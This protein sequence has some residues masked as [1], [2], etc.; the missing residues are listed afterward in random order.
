MSLYSSLSADSSVFSIQDLLGNYRSATAHHVY[1]LFTCTQCCG[2][3]ASAHHVHCLFTCTQY[4]GG[5][6]SAWPVD[7]VTQCAEKILHLDPKNSLEHYRHVFIRALVLAQVTESAF[8]EYVASRRAQYSA[9]WAFILPTAN[10]WTPA[11]DVICPV[12]KMPK[13]VGKPQKRSIASFFKPLSQADRQTSGPSAA[14]NPHRKSVCGWWTFRD[15][16]LASTHREWSIFFPIRLRNCLPKMP[17]HPKPF[18][19]LRPRASLS[20]YSRL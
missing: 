2:G 18:A 5:A 1:C 13:F 3:A 15:N 16:Y 6:A 12:H 20:A 10:P 7:F 11:T 8:A 17:L 9:P 14:S 19:L 4:C